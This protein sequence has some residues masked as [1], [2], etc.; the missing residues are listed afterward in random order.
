MATEANLDEV[1][2]EVKRM[3]QELKLLERSLNHVAEMFIAEEKVSPEEMKELEALKNEA[4]KRECVPFNK[5]LR[6]H[7]T[8]KRP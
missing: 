5:V 4:L 2:A 6:K 1:L 3:K 8:K 7:G